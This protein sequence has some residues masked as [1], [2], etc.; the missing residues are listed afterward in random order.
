MLKTLLESAKAVVNRS[1]ASLEALVVY[2]MHKVVNWPELINQILDAVINN[3]GFIAPVATQVRLEKRKLETK[4]TRIENKYRQSVG[5]RTKPE[6]AHS[7]YRRKGAIDCQPTSPTTRQTHEPTRFNTHYQV[8][9]MYSLTED[10]HRP[11][12]SKRSTRHTMTSRLS[13]KKSNI[14]QIY[15]VWH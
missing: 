5:V 10:A 14:R 6:P 8:T 9:K 4:Q 13:L 11:Y 12:L 2:T 3:S 15:V 7:R 1:L